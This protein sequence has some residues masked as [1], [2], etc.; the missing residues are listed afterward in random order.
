MTPLSKRIWF[1]ISIVSVAIV[2]N[3]LFFGNPLHDD[4]R[5]EAPLFAA[6]FGTRHIDLNDEVGKKII[7]VNF[8]ATWCAPCR[9]EVRLLNQLIQQVASDKFMIV[10]IME[11]NQ[12]LDDQA[13]QEELTRFT[14]IVPVDYPVYSDEGG[15]IAALY[16]TNKLPESYLIDADGDIIEKQVGPYSPQ[17]MDALAQQIKAEINRL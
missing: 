3:L 5:R 12:A 17:Q 11:D 15:R 14:E 1:L 16:G 6:Q 10:A 4:K 7:L 8:W 2:I 9:E 13:R